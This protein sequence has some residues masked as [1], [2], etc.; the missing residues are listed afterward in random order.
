MKTSKAP[1][2]VCSLPQSPRV[3]KLGCFHQLQLIIPLLLAIASSLPPT[4]SAQTCV[5]VNDSSDNIVAW[6]PGEGNA[7]DALM[8]NNGTLSSG[9][10]FA[11]GEVGQAFNF[12]AGHSG[13]KIPA[14]A[15][16]NVGQRD[17]YNDINLGID[18][19]IKPADISTPQPIIQWNDGAG[20]CLWI[21]VSS[22]GSVYVGFAGQTGVSLSSPGGLI[23][24][25]SFHH[26]A[27]IYDGWFVNESLLLYVDGAQV[28]IANLSY[29]V[30]VTSGEVTLGFSPPSSR[31]IGQ[32]D[33]AAVYQFL[34]GPY[35][36]SV[37]NAGSVGL[38]RL[39][40]IATQPT[41]QTVLA[42]T[43]A[44]FSVGVASMPLPWGYQWQ[45]NGTNLPDATNN[46]LTLTNVQPA[47]AGSYTVIVTNYF[48]SITSAPAILSVITSPVTITTQ[49]ASQTA[50]IGNDA[51]FAVVASGSGPYS[52]QWLFKGTNITGATGSSYTV[53]A[54]TA[55]SGNYAVL[56]SNPATSILSSNA[57]L[58]LQPAVCYPPPSGLLG[59]WPA[60]GHA[61]DIIGG[62]DGVL[63]GV[64]GFGAGKVGQD[65]SFA[66]VGYVR[67]PDGTNW[68]FGTSD[69]S[70][71]LWASFNSTQTD[72][73]FV[74][75][76]EGAGLN[77]WSFGLDNGSLQF[78]IGTASD[79][80]VQISSSP[81]T[82]VFGSFYHLA[83]TQTGGIY[84][85]YVNGNPV[86]SVT[87]STPVPIAYAPLTF[88]QSGG[89]GY[90]N[91][92]LDEIAIYNRALSASEILGIFNAGSGGKC[93][94]DSLPIITSQPA[95]QT[96]TT[97][98]NVTLRAQA[99]SLLPLSCQWLFNAV[100]VT[101]ATN[102]ALT[103]YNVS[104]SQAGFY[105][106][107][108]SNALGSVSSRLAQL[109][110]MPNTNI[111]NGQ[112]IIIA[113]PQS[114]MYMPS[115]PATISVT[116]TG[117]GPLHYQWYLNGTLLSGA[118]SPT[119]SIPGVTPTSAGT[120]QVVVS[121]GA[122]S[123]SSSN[124]VVSIV[125][126][127]LL[128][129][130]N[131]SGN[132]GN[133]S[134]YNA[135]VGTDNQAP[136]PPNVVNLGQSGLCLIANSPTGGQLNIGLNT[137]N[138]GTVG[139]W[140]MIGAYVGGPADELSVYC[141]TNYVWSA[142]YLGQETEVADFVFT[143]YENPPAQYTGW[144]FVS[145]DIPIAGKSAG[146]TWFAWTM[147]YD[148]P[149]LSGSGEI[150]DVTIS[151]FLPPLILTP[152]QDQIAL[153][154]ETVVFNVAAVGD[155]SMSYQWQCNGTNLPG[156]TSSTLTLANVT[157]NQSG[158][159]RV[160]VNNSLGSVL[161]SGAT[162]TVNPNPDVIDFQPQNQTV[163]YGSNATYSVVAEGAGPLSFQWQFD[164]ANIS[165]ATNSSFTLA[166]FQL[167]NIGSYQVVVSNSLG[168][169]TS[170]VATLNP[171]PANTY[172]LTISTSGSTLSLSWPI[173]ASGFIL[174]SSTNLVPPIAWS[175]VTDI[176][177][178]NGQ[179][180]VVSI[181]MTGSAAYYRLRHP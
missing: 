60:D 127:S 30:P 160:L 144:T 28:A 133:F 44:S 174:E 131:F 63:Q 128:Y 156:A 157:T 33:E 166:N 41:N 9:V 148:P 25:N 20:L 36:Q 95:D 110:V 155:H 22:P 113:Q 29:G 1:A 13:V 83:V 90:L 116:A 134:L 99:A 64:V 26:I 46:P 59:W 42:G 57:T 74:G 136:T 55:S 125:P 108:A 151:S 161:S 24:T 126:G 170:A 85:F 70:I 150:D 12:S 162:L 77:R 65:F 43:N 124:A 181:P 138:G 107:V 78:Q 141:G 106:I 100:P 45:F 61:R 167:A 31:F 51:T 123:V 73:F 153:S 81:F 27:V 179:N 173:A 53:N 69:F 72:N 140:M 87:N 66:S 84:T 14:S 48:D 38:C 169:I 98:S 177:A 96:A 139:F 86:G 40:T 104:A 91:G 17:P 119:L 89:Q 112:P 101:G 145:A 120:Y 146:N 6:W 121:N 49:P 154:G 82:P 23:N 10:S 168:S 71:E 94:S 37:Y 16:L 149:N 34:T 11:P 52:Y 172:S 117:N 3:R 105:Q 7:G 21:S 180:N 79:G 80:S 39:P 147:N 62:N 15:S 118:N 8:A 102:L 114:Q 32:I 103:L 35:I 93:E 158:A 109:T 163:A 137:S 56:V 5:P 171:P 130:N 4:S 159:Y 47:N 68:S 75:H 142:P 58:T 115:D 132:T 135:G 152:L 176:P 76:D 178:T 143:G 54:Q 175:A 92:Q 67:V 122:G 50:T 2:I 97:G 129:F 111:N 19:W 164:G 88:G 165:G 18:V